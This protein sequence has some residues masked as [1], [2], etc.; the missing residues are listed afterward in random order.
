MKA[1]HNWPDKINPVYVHTPQRQAGT[2]SFERGSYAFSYHADSSEDISLTMPQQVASYNSGVLHPVFQ[3]NIPEG[4]VRERLTEKL[5]RYVKVNDMLFLALQQ[6]C[7]IGR[8]SYKSDLIIETEN[9]DSLESLVNWDS[10][11]SAFEY[12][13]DKYLLNTAAISGVQP[14]LLVNT[15]KPSEK[16]TLIEPEL[17]VKTGGD[18]YENLALNEYVC[19]SIARACGISVP[20]FWLSKN[21]ELFIMKRFDL[22]NGQALGMED[23][24]VLM[25]KSGDDKYL[26][27]YENVAK[28]VQLYTRD[29]EQT[30][31]IFDYV[32]I[33][34]LLGNG[35]AHLKNFALLY[36]NIN[37]VSGLRL[38]P[39][40]DV[41]NT[42]VYETDSHDLALKMDKSREFPDRDRLIRYGKSIGVENPEQRLEEMADIARDFIDHFDRWSLFPALK[43]TLQASVSR[44]MSTS[45]VGVRFNVKRSKKRKTDRYL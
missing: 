24:A 9:H 12:L 25:K 39:L 20:E 30:R 27:S 26:G 14:K 4:Y 38:S 13:L 33:S 40:Y 44:A 19:M 42:T 29:V 21:N 3:M 41:V 22:K 36:D 34:C 10:R 32:A 28:V 17:I 15:Q 1:F 35:D 7:G 23:F 37:P 31:R 8:L 18:D 6:H 16:G 11:E 43:T 2:L 45:D 5:R